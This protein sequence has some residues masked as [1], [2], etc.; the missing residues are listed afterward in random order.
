MEQYKPSEISLSLMNISE[1]M[2]NGVNFLTL[3]G[4]MENGKKKLKKAISIL[5]H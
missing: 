5:K 4:T 1:I 2:S 3:R